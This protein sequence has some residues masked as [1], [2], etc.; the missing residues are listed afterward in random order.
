M[1]HN[2]VTAYSNDKHTNK[3][4]NIKFNYMIFL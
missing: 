4:I 2:A 3:N 1:P